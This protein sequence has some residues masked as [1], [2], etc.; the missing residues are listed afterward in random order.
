MLVIYSCKLSYFDAFTDVYL[1]CVLV[2]GRLLELEQK[3]QENQMMKQYLNKLCEEEAEK[4]GKKREEQAALREEL[5]AC[6]A[7]IL[8]RKEMAKEQE[9]IIEQRVIQ[10]QEE[11]AVSH[12]FFAKNHQVCE[13]FL[14]V[15]CR[16]DLLGFVRVICNNKQ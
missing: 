1:A 10:F 13:I 6:N 5:N 16:I 7:D 9:K 3:D 12:H 15:L 14:H 11:K 2:Q 8:R 4:I